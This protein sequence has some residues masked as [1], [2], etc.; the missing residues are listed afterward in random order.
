MKAILLLS[1][2][3]FVVSGCGLTSVTPEIGSGTFEPEPVLPLENSYQN[4]RFGYVFGVPEGRTV[5]A[6]THEQ[7]A[8]AARED[9]DVIFLV[10][11]ETNFFTVRGIEDVRSSH[12]WITKNLPFF[13]PTGDA[14]QQVGEF[15]GA[16][17]IFL[18]GGGTATS[19]ARLIVLSW[20]G[21]L[22]VISYEQDTGTFE[23]L[24]ETFQLISRALTQEDL[25]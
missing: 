23:E 17:A 20:N 10:E 6:L 16:Q 14:A 11:G 12:E 9:S 24:M 22:I 19:P 21:N 4:T 2:L 8:V 5:Y 7:T 25:A 13:Y 3:V 18:R 1:A 15:A